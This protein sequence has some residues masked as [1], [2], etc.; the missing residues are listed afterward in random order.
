MNNNL[1]IPQSDIECSICL[2]KIKKRSLWFYQRSKIIKFWL[3]IEKIA[4]GHIF[5]S[6]CI[7]MVYKSQCPLCEYPIF[8]KNEKTILK[9]NNSSKITI[10]LKTYFD[11]YGKFNN[12]YFYIV[13]S[14]SSF[15]LCSTRRNSN[16]NKRYLKILKLSYKHCDFT[17]ILAIALKKSSLDTSFITYEKMKE[18]IQTARINWHT[19][20]NGKTLF[21]LAIENTDNLAIINLI[22]DK[23]GDYHQLIP[24]APIFDE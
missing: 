12:L 22:I 15:S 3:N 1:F 6:S 4:C 7:N 5:H 17:D 9:C 18:L 19:T 13:K 14:L 24:S 2:D 10:L 11:S 21:E 23:I 8:N 20:F 16:K